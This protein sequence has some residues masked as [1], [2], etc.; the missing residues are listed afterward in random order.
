[1]NA[2]FFRVFRR[3]QFIAGIII[4]ILLGIS[5]L[6]TYGIIGNFPQQ[7][8]IGYPVS[9]YSL[10][11]LVLPLPTFVIFKFLFPI[12]STV[13]VGDLI[14]EDFSTGYIKS[15]VSHLTL[16]KYLKNNFIASFVIG[17]SISSLVVIINFI[18]L[19]MFV[20]VV[21][22]NRY[23]SMFLVD[24]Q[25]FFPSLYYDHSFIYWLIRLGLV[26]I[27]A[28]CISIIASIVSFYFKNRYI[29]IATPMILIMLIDMMIRLIESDPYT[30]SSQFIG[31]EKLQITGVLFVSLTILA[32]IFT[33][34]Y[35]AKNNEL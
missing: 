30:I 17:G 6:Q 1:M 34:F 29:A 13:A 9:I 19:M 12:I 4:S 25:E 2:I 27:F 32:T 14:A 16:K 24:S 22:L 26:F 35:G 31:T 8:Y 18:T 33:V 28:G 10:Q 21:P 11:M 7:S 3:K 23:Y 15:L 5:S 20:P